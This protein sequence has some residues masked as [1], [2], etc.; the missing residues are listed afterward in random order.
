MGSMLRSDKMALCDIYL[1]PE[2]AFEILSQ[3]GEVGCV[4]FL[5]MN[6]D[7]QAFQ[8]NY[9]TEVCRCA[10]MERKLRY[11]E[12]ELL[13]DNIYV[14]DSVQEPKALQPNEMI[15]YEN[16]L[17]KWKNDIT[18]MSENHTKLNKSY[19]ELNE[20]LYVL[21]QIG[22]LLGDNDMRRDSK[23]PNLRGADILPGGHLIVMPGVVRRSK[24]YHFEMML[25]RVSRGN[26]YYR[27]ATED[28]ILKDPF[29][30]MEIRKV[31][32]LAVC[33][34][35]ELSTRMEKIFSGFRVNSYPC[36][37]SA[38]ERLEM[39]S[40]LETRMSDLE[41]IL[42]KSKYIRCK[43]L[44]T[45]GKQ[46][47]NGIVQVKKAKAIYHTMNL[48]SLDITKKCLI[49]QCW[50]PE[51]DL[52]RVQD[53]LVECSETIGTNVPSFISKT[54]FSMSPPTFN[55]TNKYTH[56]FQV[57]INAY[58]DSMYRELNPA[59]YTI[60]SFPFL[61]ALMFGDM[62][63]ALILL[64]FS[65][66][67]VKNEEKFIAMKSRNEI[68]NIIFGGRYIILLMGM[69]SFFSGVVYNDCFGRSI[70]P[71]P[72]YWVN[73]F[74]SEALAK[75]SVLNLD[76]KGKTRNLY[77][78]GV[79]PVW[80]VAKNNII[81]E[82]S[83]KMKFSIIV[84]VL[85][86]IFGLNLSVVNHW[87]LNRRYLIVFQ[88]IPEIVF[89][90][91]IFMWLVLLMFF[92][93]FMYSGKISGKRG[94]NCAPQILI[95]FIDMFLW[96][97]TKPVGAN[98]DAYMFNKQELVQKILMIIAISCIPLLLLGTPVYLYCTNKKKT[99]KPD[100]KVSDFRRYQRRDSD[101]ERKE[102]KKTSEKEHDS[103]S[104]GDLMIHQAVH[105]I[106]FVLSTISHTASY[107]RLWA[108]SLAH[109]ELSEMLWNMV[110]SKLA[111]RDY[112]MFGA[113]KVFIIFSVWVMFTI[114]ILVVMEGL[115]AFL[116]TLRLH[117]VEFM[118]KFY[119]GGGYPFRPFSFENILTAETEK[120]KGE[121]GGATHDNSNNV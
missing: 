19:L 41:E 76:P 15:A 63:H 36:P 11:V 72:S 97:K 119:I 50:I 34:G 105:T 120:S 87:Y 53:I 10:E 38:K 78:L 100:V 116:H 30:G 90:T 46:W 51:R 28:K 42:S 73:T 91:C 86:M 89:L 48:F 23:F 111:L 55:R 77:L 26:I 79:D 80:G 109:V 27:Q 52:M 74:S 37:E 7:V 13:K 92:K 25:W 114:S 5:D 107:L 66:W 44:R 101:E 70:V 115:S 33:Q 98:C 82:N 1:Q 64:S 84:G 94:A 103:S 62:G 71:M 8:R 20:M 69:F 117:W 121:K 108:L 29:T 59:L 31:A 40:Q 16:I 61:F 112:S 85:H 58:G 32:F 118:S 65:T 110:L 96:T 21:N 54:T 102:P 2:A 57:L 14:P 12:A 4:Q 17:E 6:P 3:L 47:Q 75:Q 60:I 49:G 9:I 45:V 24:S 106:E 35:E 43:T 104:F 67:M 88:F 18:V 22:P 56:G 113:I 93:W 83:I 81:Y 95:L 99:Q 39:I 68:W